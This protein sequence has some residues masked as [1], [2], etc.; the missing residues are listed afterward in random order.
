MVLLYLFCFNHWGNICA[1]ISCLYIGLA[2]I[3][4]SRSSGGWFDMD[5]LNLLFPLLIVWTYLMVYKT[6]VFKLKTLWIFF[7]SFWVG[8]FCFTWPGWWFIFLVVI[9]YEIFS[10][11][12]LLFVYWRGNEKDLVLLKRRLLFLAFFLLFSCLWIIV[13]SGLAPLLSL[14]DQLKE[15]ITL[16]KPLT[17]FL[18]PN[19]FS[20]VGELRR[21]DFYQIA[22]AAGGM[23]LFLPALVSILILLIRTLRNKKCTDFEREF[24]LILLFWFMSMFFASLKGIRFVMF[25][26]IP[27]G[28][29]L[30]WI[31]NEAYTYFKNKKKGVHLIV[32]AT[33]IILL[34]EFINNGYREAKQSFP[35]MDDNWNKILT[36][37]KEKTPQKAVINSWWDFG[38]WFKAVSKRKVIFDGQSQNV[39][40]A[41]W[42]AY[43]LLTDNEEEA[44][45]ILRMLNNGGNSA[46]EAINRHLRD[47]FK[48]VLLLKRVLLLDSKE[49]KETLMKFLPMPTAKEVIK[50]IFD[51]PQ[52]AY[53]I[54]DYTMLE[55]IRTISFLGNWDFAKVYLAYNIN[56]KGKNRITDYLKESIMDK[57]KIDKLYQEATLISKDNL[58]IWIS[59]RYNFYGKLVNGQIKNDIVLFDNGLVYNPKEQTIF[60]Y[61]P[62]DT[63]YKIPKSLFL[64][65]NSSG[66][67]KETV[68]PGNDLD[69]SALILKNQENYQAILLD[70]Q[71]AKSLFVRLYFLNG[72]GLKYF[73]PFTE[74]NEDGYIRV[75]EIIWG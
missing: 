43:A 66:A 54:V 23:G 51:R 45:N 28:V 34:C 68:Y 47:P 58:D 6:N 57:Q 21:P 61:Y 29:S 3:F 56:K 1:I 30:G 18:W 65:E 64:F 62:R 36:A 55:K 10:L 69:F 2:P 16:N 46:F 27:L 25:I 70:S 5:I 8:L 22:N 38:D 37:L 75:F 40:Q 67:L 49:A 13:F 72:S 32:G 17:G 39:P 9:L 71:L 52:R 60:L 12:S 24:R 63:K 74:E 44:I 7:S 19:V 26:L 15:A 50:L 53:F 35:L 41:Y 14:S 4:L 73:K 59:H 11:V 42:M 31:I 33:L 20:T 48:S